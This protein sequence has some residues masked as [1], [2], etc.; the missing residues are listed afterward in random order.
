MNFVM[1]TATNT[2]NPYPGL[3]PF[4]TDETKFYFGRE[5]QTSIA[6]EKIKHNRFL[7]IIGSSGSGKSS[8]INAGII[9]G[10]TDKKRKDVLPEWRIINVRP[11]TTPID[12]LAYALSRSIKDDGSEGSETPTGISRFLQDDHNG[13][14][15]LFHQIRRNDKEKV[16]IVIDHFEELFS[17]Q[18][19]GSGF[20]VEGKAADFINLIIAI[21]KNENLPVHI[22]L[23]IRSGFLEECHQITQLRNLIDASNYI[24]P[25]FTTED[26]RQIINGPA[27]VWGAEIDPGLEKQLIRE[28]FDNSDQ[29]T[30]LQHVLN[31][32]WDFWLEQNV[33]QPISLKEYKAVG[34]IEEAISTHADGIYLE[35]PEVSRRTCERMFKAITRKVSDN[36]EIGVPLRVSDIAVITRSGIPEVISIVARFRQTGCSFLMPYKGQLDPGSVIELSHESLMR[37]WKRLQ[38]WVEEEAESVSTY[39]HLAETSRLY[40]MGKSKLLSEQALQQALLWKEK[41]E[42]TSQWAQRHNPAFERTMQFLIISQETYEINEYKS[43]VRARRTSQL[44]RAFTVA[45]LLSVLITAGVIIYHADFLPGIISRIEVMIQGNS[46]DRNNSAGTDDPSMV[47]DPEDET[48]QAEQNQTTGSP[49]QDDPAPSSSEI[50]TPLPSP[51]SITQDQQL[52]DIPALDPDTSEILPR[53]PAPSEITTQDPPPTQTPPARRSIIAQN[54]VVRRVIP[55]PSSSGDQTSRQNE[56]LAD[57]TA[58]LEAIKGRMIAI[59][60]SLAVRSLQV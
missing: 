12:N 41:N 38:V 14:S 42:P 15:K 36:L 18:P 9:P 6:I 31:R 48:L 60:Q 20:L 25:P 19:G 7:A 29:L 47:A 34:G 44:L 33:D 59:S 39:M 17:L 16:L 30:L 52:S 2:Y 53:E 1:A 32:M 26:L 58:S 8:L 45:A 35:L 43:Y 51:E 50:S 54:D 13:F 21:N 10:L 49:E 23:A 57:A 56:Q 46:I 4:N 27:A 11:G 3:R 55:P 22:L 37:L 24:L 5:D 40:Q 28:I